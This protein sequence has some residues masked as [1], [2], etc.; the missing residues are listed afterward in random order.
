LLTVATELIARDD[1]SGGSQV[2]DSAAYAGLVQLWRGRLDQAGGMLS[3]ER[4]DRFRA[5]GDA[6]HLSP[7]LVAVALRAMAEG[8]QPT[9]VALIE[10]MGEATADDDRWRC[11]ASMTPPASRWLP[12]TASWPC[13][14]FRRPPR[15]CG[16]TS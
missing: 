14:S 8:D 5:I 3:A 11:L 13:G 2:G 9:A 16:A 15:P 1:A 6:Q 12:V 10:E 4:L 7:W